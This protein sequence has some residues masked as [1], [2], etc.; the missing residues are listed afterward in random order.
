MENDLRLKQ[1]FINIFGKSTTSSNHKKIFREMLNNLIQFF[2]YGGSIILKKWQQGEHFKHNKKWITKNKTKGIKNQLT[3]N[4]CWCWRRNKDWQKIYLPIVCYIPWE[5]DCWT[6]E[7]KSVGHKA[8][9][10][11]DKEHNSFVR[12]DHW[13]LLCLWLLRVSLE[14]L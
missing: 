13:E 2:N 12:K 8:K 9:D 10:F 5:I 11:N 4:N 6:W 1:T 7:C 14:K 3:E